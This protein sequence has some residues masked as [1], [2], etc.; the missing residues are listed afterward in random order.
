M[1]PRYQCTGQEKCIS[2]IA[3]VFH[4]LFANFDQRLDFLN[5]LYWQLGETGRG[6][7]IISSIQRLVPEATPCDIIRTSV[8]KLLAKGI[9][10]ISVVHLGVGIDIKNADC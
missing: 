7:D 6:D 4:V 5:F 3:H 1:H 8:L 9:P 2:K 10:E